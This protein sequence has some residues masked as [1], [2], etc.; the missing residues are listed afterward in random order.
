MAEEPKLPSLVRCPHCSS[1]VREDR[2][3]THKQRLHRHIL[4]P[5][6]SPSNRSKVGEIAESTISGCLVTKC[7]I[8]GAVV[9]PHRLERHKARVHTSP[10]QLRSQAKSAPQPPVPPPK[11]KKVKKVKQ[12]PPKPIRFQNLPDTGYNELW[13]QQQEESNFFASLM[14]ASPTSWSSTR[15]HWLTDSSGAPKRKT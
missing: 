7:C 6:G 11:S 4:T 2:L 10:L 5:K 13:A 9:R 3:E 8:C 1:M 14:V 12:D 15:K